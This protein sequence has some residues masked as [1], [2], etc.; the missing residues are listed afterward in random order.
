MPQLRRNEWNFS[1]NVAEVIT[2]IL[3][4]PEFGDSPLGHAEP[5][6][7]EVRGARRLDLV[8]FG[9]QDASNPIVT[10][11]LKVP[12]DAMGRNPHNATLVEGAHGKASRAGALYFVTWNIRRV[13]VWKTDDPGVALSERVLYDEE[14]IPSHLS[15]A[16]ATD[17]DSPEIHTAL[18]EGVR[19]LVAFLH[20]LVTGPPAPA[21]L[22]L[23]RL[24]IARIESALDYP[25]QAVITSIRAKNKS[26]TAS[27]EDSRSG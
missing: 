22:P 20:K 3:G 12:W 5:E 17:L 16:S 6:L 9:R 26:S 13:V 7:T 21:F 4:E 24:F 23:D 1:S 19:E 11:E 2:T 10:G 25:I 8:I 14:I 27:N 18:K 15:L